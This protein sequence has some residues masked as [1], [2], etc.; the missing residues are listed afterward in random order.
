MPHLRRR[1][2]RQRATPLLDG[3]TPRPGD[4]PVAPPRTK[5][6]PKYVVDPELLQQAVR[7]LNADALMPAAGHK[8]I[9]RGTNTLPATGAC[10]DCGRAVSG[11]RRFCGPC[12]A[13]H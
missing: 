6:G 13:K 9:G 1:T 8:V 4:E 5:P 12:V 3:R 7:R 11:E 10:H 2:S